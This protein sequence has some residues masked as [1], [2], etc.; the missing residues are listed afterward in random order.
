MSSRPKCRV[1][2]RETLVLHHLRGNAYSTLVDK[3]YV[4]A[5]QP[6]IE[7]RLEGPTGSL[8]PWVRLSIVE[9]G[10]ANHFPYSQSYLLTSAIIGCK[11]VV[12]I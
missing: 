6:W 1:N 8:I 4:K 11:S 2:S 7:R 5:A 12:K 9:Q 10:F 3:S